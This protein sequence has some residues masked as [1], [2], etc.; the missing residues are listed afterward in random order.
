[1]SFVPLNRTIRTSLGFENALRINDIDVGTRWNKGP[2]LI[3]DNSLKLELYSITPMRDPKSILISSRLN[4][5]ISNTM[6]MTCSEMGYNTISML[7][8]LHNTA[9]TL[10]QHASRGR[11]WSRFWCMRWSG[12]RLRR[13][14]TGWSRQ[15][16]LLGGRRRPGWKWPRIGRLVRPMGRSSRGSIARWSRR[17]QRGC[18]ARWHGYRDRAKHGY[19][20]GAMHRRRSGKSINGWGRLI[21]ELKVSAATNSC[22]MVR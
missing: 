16:R 13:G 14:R 18:T 10:C 17:G 5:G 2:C 4:S 20:H 21:R 7:L 8:L 6:S 22:T 3:L 15:I 12:R 19:K 9:L 11:S 1:M